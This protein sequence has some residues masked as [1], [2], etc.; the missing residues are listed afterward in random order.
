MLS[1]SS[2]FLHGAAY[3]HTYIRN[4]IIYTIIMKHHAGLK[5]NG[6][7][8]IFWLLCLDHVSR[9]CWI[10]GLGLLVKFDLLQ[11]QSPKKTTTLS[12]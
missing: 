6:L 7:A 12:W 10:L 9:V 1:S 11:D 4:V 2:Y 8:N 5:Y 3:L